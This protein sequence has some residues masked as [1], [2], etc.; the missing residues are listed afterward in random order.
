[1]NEFWAAIAGALVG[2]G[3]GGAISAAL[4]A[5]ALHAAKKERAAAAEAANEERHQA[6]R[7]RDQSVALSLLFKV[8]QM[9]LNFDGY[10]KAVAAAVEKAARLSKPGLPELE[11]WQSMEPLVTGINR[12]DLSGGEKAILL[13][14]G[15]QK[16]FFDAVNIDHIHNHTVA[17]FETYTARRLLLTDT[18]PAEVRGDV[19]TLQLTEED[20]RRI[21]PRAAELNSMVGQMR[22]RAE[23]DARQS[24]ALYLA[25]NQ[26]IEAKFGVSVPR[27]EA[28]TN[29][30][31]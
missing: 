26:A 27:P 25:L 13:S 29:Q 15:D 8:R 31:S 7:R 3:I 4:Q 30:S 1:M 22:R 10:A 2:S 14:L 11:P 9:T 12:I 5:W 28:S 20:K 18:L 16:L 23:E 17:L 21:A 6:D 24:L 19:G